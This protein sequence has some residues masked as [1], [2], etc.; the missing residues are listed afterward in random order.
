M[1]RQV[2]R[3]GKV[4]KL[5]DTCQLTSTKFIKL[6]E[7]LYQFFFIEK[8]FMFCCLLIGGS[9]EHEHSG[10][11]SYYL[12]LSSVNFE[13]LYLWFSCVQLFTFTRVEVRALLFL[14]IYSLQLF[15]NYLCAGIISRSMKSLKI[16]LL[17]VK[18]CLL[19]LSQHQFLLRLAPQMM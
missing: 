16:Q 14:Y 9:L 1:P 19:L 17:I 2:Y 5:K 10:P 6:C 8:G 4:K 15:Q 13:R 3:D 11:H 18:V 12:V 7:I